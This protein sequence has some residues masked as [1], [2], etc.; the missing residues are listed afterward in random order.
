MGLFRRTRKIENTRGAVVRLEWRGEG[1]REPV[2]SLIRAL[3]AEH[4]AALSHPQADLVHATRSFWRAV[5]DATV[6]HN[7]AMKR[8]L[9]SVPRAELYLTHPAA[10]Q[11]IRRAIDQFADR[12]GVDAAAVGCWGSAELMNKETR[13]RW[14]PTPKG[15]WWDD[16]PLAFACLLTP[17]DSPHSSLAGLLAAADREFI[18]T[19]YADDVPQL[20][21]TSEQL[22]SAA[23]EDPSAGGVLTF[24]PG[25]QWSHARFAAPGPLPLTVAIRRAG[26]LKLDPAPVMRELLEEAVREGSMDAASAEAI[27]KDLNESRAGEDPS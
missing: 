24:K 25:G 3:V 17:S 26:L 18:F 27:L 16:L 8:A 12:F 14:R 10:Q 11:A 15:F 2:R 7:S 6:W 5:A 1:E 13:G 9:R 21:F 22:A 19:P 23:A 4:E 20:I